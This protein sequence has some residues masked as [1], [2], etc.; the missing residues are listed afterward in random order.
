MI[1][2]VDGLKGLADA[3]TMVYAQSDLHRA[4][5]AQQAGLCGLERAQACCPCPAPD[6]HDQ[7]D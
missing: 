6:L 3:L 4:S 1:A 2:V 7:C 5:A